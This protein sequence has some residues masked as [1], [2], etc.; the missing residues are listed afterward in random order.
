MKARTFIETIEAART[1]KGGRLHTSMAQAFQEVVEELE[2]EAVQEEAELEWERRE[3]RMQR[4]TRQ[5][6]KAERKAQ[7]GKEQKQ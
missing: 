6:A 2:A 1:Q 3:H 7:A 5:Q 4:R